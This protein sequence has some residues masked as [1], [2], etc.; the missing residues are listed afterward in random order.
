MITRRHFVIGASAALI[1]APA[2]VRAGSLMPVRSLIIN[3]E[4]IYGFCDRLN[5]DWRYRSGALRGPAL[6]RIIND[7]VLRHIPPDKLAYDL[8]TWGTAPLSLAAREQ[9][10][11]VLWPSAGVLHFPKS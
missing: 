6:L 7:G 2:I 1:T 3:K 5:I 4:R 10:S 9:R 11:A 8:A